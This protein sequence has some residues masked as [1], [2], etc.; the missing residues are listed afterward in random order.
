[1]KGDYHKFGD[2]LDAHGAII[3][4]GQADSEQGR[5]ELIEN[6][7]EIRDLAD[8]YVKT[9]TRTDKNKDVKRTMGVFR[10]L[11]DEKLEAIETEPKQ[12]ENPKVV[13]EEAKQQ[14]ENPKVVKEEPKPQPENLQQHQESSQA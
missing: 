6:L 1:M 2:L 3:S 14:P 12:P 5:A 9:E 10:R 11:A 7:K 8:K 13:E 4:N